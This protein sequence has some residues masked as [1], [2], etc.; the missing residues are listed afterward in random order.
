MLMTMRAYTEGCRAFGGWVARNLD[1]LKHHPDAE[2][3]QEAEDFT[4]L[5]TPIVKALFT[6][7]GFE[8]AS[9]GMQVYGGHGFI[10][11]HGMEQYVRDSRI[12]MIYEG[13]NG[14]QAL[15]LVGR[16]MP[17]HMGRYLRS[18]FHPV[19]AEIDA[20]IDDER[21]SDLVQPLSKAFGGLQ[22]CTA[23]IAQKGMKDPE[24]AGAAATEYLRLFGLVALGFMWLK[25][26][27]V[28]HE[29]LDGNCDDPAFYKAKLTTAHFFMTRI[30]PQAAGLVAS[31]RS[32]KEAMMA[33]DEM[34]F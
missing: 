7:L 21:L 30:L 11:D 12:S 1:M 18:F 31:I 20:A 24:E 16:K 19:L 4:A 2:K 33:L 10:R 9:I 23:E 32:G 17:A 25:S 6:D 3:R 28:A 8:T 13:T 14:I 29:A 27:K 15:D 22:L 5:M 34:A 26:A